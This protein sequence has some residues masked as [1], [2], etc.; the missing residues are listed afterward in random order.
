[1]S[2]IT[3]T[4]LRGLG[5]VLP[6]SLTIWF[7]VWL[8]VTTES[9]LR[10]V[11]LVILP[12]GLYLPGLGLIFGIVMVY[13]VGVLAQIFF[14]QSLWRHARNLLDRIPLVKTVY[15]AISDFYQFFSSG[16]ADGAARVVSVDVSDDVSVIGFVTGPSPSFMDQGGSRRIAV[17]FPMS[18]QIGGYT[19]MV[20]EDRVS[21]LDIGVEDAMRV[22]LTASVRSRR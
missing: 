8:A 6:L 18:Y 4:F 5:V 22:I 12:E 19:L 7:V 13:G 2:H 21:P 14:L 15:T 16:P 10:S 17:Y 1:M 9:L 20:P 11:F 3:T